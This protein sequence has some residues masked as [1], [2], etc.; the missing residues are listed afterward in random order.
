MKKL[1]ALVLALVL[2]LA[3]CAVAFA[4]APTTGSI[5]V[6][7]NNNG[8]TYTL[9][10]LFD[11]EITF[12]GNDTDGYTQAAITYKKNGE[13]GTVGSK[14]FTENSNGFIEPT[15][16]LTADAMKSREFIDWAKSYGT[17]VGSAITAESDN[18]AN[19]KWTNLE[20]G[21]YLVDSTLGSFIG[22]DSDNPNA[23]IQD[24]N[25]P[26][27]LDKKIKSVKDAAANDDG[28]IWDAT[29]ASEIQFTG[30]GSNEHAIAQIG[31][32]ITYTIEV[33]IKP[34]AEAYVVTDTLDA[35]LTPPASL[36][37]EHATVSIDGQV[38]TVTFD[39]DYLDTI[40]TDT[41]VSFDYT[42]TLNANAVVADVNNNTA[43]LEW[44]HKTEKDHT[45]DES[46][47]WTAK[48]GVDK[49]INS[50]TGDPLSGAGFVLK[51]SA[52]KYFKRD[53]QTDVVTW[54][55][56]IDNA[57]EYVTGADGK[58]SPEFAGL[59]NGTYTLV[60]KTVP[61]GYNKTG[62]TQITINGSNV[63]A[64][65]LAKTAIVV[66]NA[67]T[68]LPSTGGIGTTIFYI[69]GGLLV[70]GAAVILVARRKSHD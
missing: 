21:Y 23:T 41:V 49:R 5:T 34:G 56:S 11:A 65:N 15:S 54:V 19:V 24:K 66:N 51:N 32:T 29:D 35:G 4:D 18:D 7:P 38:L 16:A 55:D 48:I 53:A 22:I 60:E 26:P 70:I 68:T 25:N 1:L 28:S 52:D 33:T 36:T 57:T 63:T 2:V 40:T 64:D 14:Y 8:Q 59:A 47:V 27:K 10:K 3:T 6:N 44:G 39:Q 17:Q 20:F 30:D 13:L 67:G 12:T 42:A 62:D 43:R 31:D 45:E 9:Y 69:V 50:E 37:V 58:I 46:K 61:D